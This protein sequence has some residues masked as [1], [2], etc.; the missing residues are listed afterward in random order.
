MPRILKYTEDQWNFLNAVE[1]HFGEVAKTSLECILAGETDSFVG[2]SRQVA[3]QIIQ[4][5][6]EYEVKISAKK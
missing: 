2:I 3:G 4:L 5:A 1:K 6:E